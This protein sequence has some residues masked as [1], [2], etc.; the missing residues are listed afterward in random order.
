MIEGSC[1]EGPNP[2]WNQNREFKIVMN[3][4]KKLI[5]M[6]FIMTAIKSLQP[7]LIKYKIQDKMILT[8]F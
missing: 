2:V 4:K 5:L 7:Y 6:K 3:Q 8:H 1:Q